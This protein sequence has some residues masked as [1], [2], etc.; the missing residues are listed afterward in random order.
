MRLIEDWYDAGLAGEGREVHAWTG[1]MTKNKANGRETFGRQSRSGTLDWYFWQGPCAQ[2][3]SNETHC[4][5]GWPL[6]LVLRIGRD[7]RWRVP[8]ARC[9]A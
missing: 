2:R 1:R 6:A 8:H 9:A 4:P 5:K 7:G 3:P